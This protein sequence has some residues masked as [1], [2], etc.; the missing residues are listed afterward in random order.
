MISNLLAWAIQA[1]ILIAAAALTPALLRVQS[2]RAQMR[3]FQLVLFGLLALPV[4]Q[5]WKHPVYS[6][7]TFTPVDISRTAAVE[8]A[9]SRPERPPFDWE[10]VVVY[11]LVAGMAARG[12]LLALGLFRLNRYRRLSEPLAMTGGVRQSRSRPKSQAR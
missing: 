9:Q 4:V 1:T 7:S 12:S 5:P 11:V 10:Q 2:A 8:P 6:A 3:T